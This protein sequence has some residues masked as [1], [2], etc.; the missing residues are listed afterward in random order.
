MQANQN[1][2]QVSGN[3]L[4]GNQMK[5]GGLQNTSWKPGMEQFAESI[6][7]RYSKDGVVMSMPAGMR[8]PECIRQ[9]DGAQARA[10]M[11]QRDRTCFGCGKEERKYVSK[12]GRVACSFE[13]YRVA[14][15]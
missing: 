3:V 4:Q 6:K 13:C 12:Q 2:Q 9:G 7:L 11:E 8:V 10:K 1:Q 15:K 5:S 14:V